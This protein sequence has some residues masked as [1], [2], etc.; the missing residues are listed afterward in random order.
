V[1]CLDPNLR[2]MIKNGPV[3]VKTVKG[4]CVSTVAE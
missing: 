3:E 2:V 4:P 1:Q